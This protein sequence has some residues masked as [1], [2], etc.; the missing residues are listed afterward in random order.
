M[1]P[2]KRNGTL[3]KYYVQVHRIRIEFPF[4]DSSALGWAIYIQLR[5]DA[6]HVAQH[7][8][9]E[10]KPPRRQPH[11]IMG[12]GSTP[13]QRCS[14]MRMLFSLRQ[15][16]RTGTKSQSSWDSGRG[17]RETLPGQVYFGDRKSPLPMR[18]PPDISYNIHC[19]HV[20][21]GAQPAEWG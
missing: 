2:E 3:F 21:W 14:W 19:C 17:E 20:Y 10:E 18:F 15:P 13:V 11:S 1:G 4:L 7:E 9:E 16:R 12:T 6:P 8:E 5:R